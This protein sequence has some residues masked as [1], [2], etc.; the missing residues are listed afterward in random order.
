MPSKL[1]RR[2]HRF[3]EQ[4]KSHEGHFKAEQTDPF[5]KGVD[6]YLGMVESLLCSIRAMLAY[7]AIRSQSAGPL[8]ICGGGTPLI[9]SFLVESLK[10]A[11]QQCGFDPDKYNGHS[12]RIGAAPT[13]AAHG[14]PEATIKML[15]RWQSSAY[16]IYIKTPRAELAAIASRLAAGQP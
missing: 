15:G 8:F 4:P 6:I 16:T 7:L 5:R 2:C 12:F 10:T 1:E 11:L 14:I 13:A 9:R 3:S